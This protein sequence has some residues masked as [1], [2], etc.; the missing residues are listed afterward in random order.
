MEQFDGDI[1]H[2]DNRYAGDKGVHAR[3]YVM[4]VKDDAAS[5]EAGRP[6]FQDKEFVEIVAAGNQNN[7]IKRKATQEDRHRFHEQYSRF[8]AGSSDQMIGTPLSEV[9]WLTR[10][11][12]EELSYMNIRSLE[13]LAN[14][15]DEACSRVAGLYDFKR[16]AAAHIE[17]AG[18]YAPVEALHRE[19]EDLK[20]QLAALTETVKEQTALLKQLQEK[21]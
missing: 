12:V 8:K 21:K 13:A 20:N 16:R 6:I 10:S 9:T 17:K 11:Q 18:Q 5:A 4:P 14:L 3:F 1:A 7:I 15:N 19:N 2:F